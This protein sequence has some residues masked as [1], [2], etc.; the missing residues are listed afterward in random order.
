MSSRLKIKLSLILILGVFCRP[1]I[2]QAL[3]DKKYEADYVL[4][5]CLGRVEVVMP[6]GTRCD[7]LTTLTAYEYDWAK[8]WAEGIGQAL[9]YAQQTRKQAGLVLITGP[10]DFRY[11]KRARETIEYHNLPIVLRT[12]PK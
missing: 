10:N 3:A 12:I 9:H 8:K 11:V 2:Q 6:D 7:C 1:L 5:H 4:Q